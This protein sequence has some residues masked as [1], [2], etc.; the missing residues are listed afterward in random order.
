VQ[1]E[2]RSEVVVG[3]IDAA[4]VN[5]AFAVTQDVFEFLVAEVLH[6]Q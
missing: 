2:L 3:G 5:Q 4:A 6:G 1:V